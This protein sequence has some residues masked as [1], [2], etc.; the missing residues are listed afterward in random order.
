MDGF[1][2]LYRT[3][4]LSFAEIKHGPLFELF[5]TKFAIILK[6]VSVH[7]MIMK[8]FWISL[9]ELSLGEM[10]LLQRVKGL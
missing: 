1:A 6:S 10:R 8:L 9:F 3:I 7:C 5:K 4:Y 2:N